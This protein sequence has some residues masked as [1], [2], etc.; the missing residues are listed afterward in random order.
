MDFRSNMILWM[1]YVYRVYV[2]IGIVD[3]GG[4]SKKGVIFKCKLGLFNFIK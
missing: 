3:V 2:N 1:C 4:L